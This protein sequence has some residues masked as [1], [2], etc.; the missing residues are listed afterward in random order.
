MSGVT[1]KQIAEQLNVSVATVSKALKGYKD[2]SPKTRKKV[3]NLVK[4]L[5]YSPNLS[6]V[7]LRTSQT[8]TI[9]III[10]TIVHHFFS[11][12]IQGVLKEAE[13]KGYMVI[14]LQSDERYEM[15]KKQIELLINKGVDG[16]LISLS[17]ETTNDGSLQKIQSRGIPIVLFDKISKTFH[18]SKVMI[19]DRL[20]AYNAVTHL[21][22]KG[23]KR[24][25]HFRGGYNPQNS[26][27]RFLGYKKALE[28]F[29]IPF[30]DSL[31]YVCDNNS[32]YEDG[33]RAAKDLIQ[34]SGKNVDALFTITDVLAVGAMKYFEDEGLRVPKDI[35]VIGFSN[36]FMS[37][38]IT[39]SLSTV[40]Q[41][42]VE[43]GKRAVEVLCDEIQAKRNHKP[44]AYQN[45]ILPTYV[46]SRDSS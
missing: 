25:A 35:A 27:D 10:P 12:V 43:M 41:P 45:I 39:P 38:V 37:S 8:K 14:L 46:I 7:S 18:C 23:Y 20:S 40:Y 33:Y 17:N 15:E 28:D 21:L 29:G 11:E 19:D 4:E 30:D 31:V 2:V 26:I 24:I 1:L 34:N 42:G 9:G 16:I 44:F 5:N 32:D 6:A 22:Q 36:W 13:A 3:E